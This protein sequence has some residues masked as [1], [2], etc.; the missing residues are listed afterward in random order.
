MLGLAILEG[1]SD[2]LDG[3]WF[4]SCKSSLFGLVVF[5]VFPQVNKIKQ[6]NRQ[7]WGFKHSAKIR[8]QN[9]ISLLSVFRGYPFQTDRAEGGEWATQL[10]GWMDFGEGASQKSLVVFNMF[11]TTWA[12]ENSCWMFAQILESLKSSWG[13]WR[14]GL[15]PEGLKFLFHQK[16]AKTRQTLDSANLYSQEIE[17]GYVWQAQNT[18]EKQPG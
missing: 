10:L 17:V 1:V 14:L 7:L 15:F 16:L 11:P 2:D 9:M 13:R 6:V 8:R 5:C 4:L 3:E 12:A 18:F